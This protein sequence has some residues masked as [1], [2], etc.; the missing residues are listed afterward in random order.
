MTIR[1]LKIDITQSILYTQYT[2]WP[3]ELFIIDFETLTSVF[4][5]RGLLRRILMSWSVDEWCLLQALSKADFFSE[6]ERG[7]LVWTK[8][9]A[10]CLDLNPQTIQT[11]TRTHQQ[12]RRLGPRWRN[13]CP[14]A[15][16]EGCWR[17][18]VLF[19]YSWPGTRARRSTCAAGTA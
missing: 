12:E 11:L 2:F 9:I 6:R 16:S 4:N 5:V 18:T 19:G 7:V 13:A 10:P 1:Q 3:C 17:S 14:S 15:Q 8:C